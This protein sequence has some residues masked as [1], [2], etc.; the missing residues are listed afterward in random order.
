M[1]ARCRAPEAEARSQA[2]PAS[3]A[4]GWRS[5]L[6]WG[7]SAAGVSSPAGL[8]GGCAP[9]GPSSGSLV[10]LVTGLSA[11]FPPTPRGT[12]PPQ[13]PHFWRLV[14]KTFKKDLSTGHHF[15]SQETEGSL[16]G[17]VGELHSSGQPPPWGSG[18]VSPEELGPH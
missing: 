18:L 6:P 14:D 9:P 13:P 8:P 17:K 4:P 1:A 12:A 15:H 3:R 11:H 2:Q 10:W 16:M 5:R 7:L